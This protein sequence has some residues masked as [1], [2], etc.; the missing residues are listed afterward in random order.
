ME[1]LNDRLNA[2]DAKKRGRVYV[3]RHLDD[4][5][6]ALDQGYSRRD[7]WQALK[8]DGQMPISYRQFNHLV[9][10]LTAPDAASITAAATA[11]TTPSPPRQQQQGAAQKPREFNPIPD[12]EDL[13]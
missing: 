4:I 11:T 7:I 1:G 5:R 3:L 10:K 13:I 2:Q 8:E 9:A 12:I 6:Q